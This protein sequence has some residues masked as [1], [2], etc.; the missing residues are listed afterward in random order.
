MAWVLTTL[1]GMSSVLAFAVLAVCAYVVMHNPN[2]SSIASRVHGILSG[3]GSDALKSQMTVPVVMSQIMPVGIMG[4]FCAVVLAAFISTND[5][6]LH[7]WG[8]VLTQD[9]ILPFRKKP[10]APAQHVLLLRLSIIGVAI[11]VFIFG[12]AFVASNS[13]AGENEWL[14]FDA[15]LAKA[16]K[17]NKSIVVDFYTDWCHWCKVMEKQTFE[18]ADVAK[19]LKERFVTVRVNAEAQ[20]EQVTFQNQK[21]SNVQLTRP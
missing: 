13:F 14:K 4:G 8:S 7:S 20:N 16:K 6:Y 1:R 12:I 17:E 10:L 21:M 3:V 2:F 11:F 9:V 19:K 15:G 5:T 18:N